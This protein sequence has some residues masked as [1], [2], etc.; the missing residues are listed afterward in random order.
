MTFKMDRWLKHLA[1]NPLASRL[2][3]LDAVEQ[4]TIVFPKGLA[5]G[6]LLPRVIR[7]MHCHD[8]TTPE[9]QLLKE[10]YGHLADLE[11]AGRGFPLDG[12]LELLDRMT[13]G[14]HPQFCSAAVSTLGDLLIWD[15]ADGLDH[16]GDDFYEPDWEI[17]S[18]P[19]A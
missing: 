8:A 6:S 14:E 18:E 13:A 16:P 10:R 12:I 7:A 3:L 11:P 17:T 4:G 1:L 5:R 19:D 9:Q 2:G 15:K